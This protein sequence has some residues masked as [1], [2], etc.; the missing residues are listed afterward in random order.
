M[1]DRKKFK[2]KKGNMKRERKLKKRREEGEG[3]DFLKDI[4]H[5]TE[6]LCKI[7]IS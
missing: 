5:S 3:E 7:K 1:E 4:D 2:G 6:L